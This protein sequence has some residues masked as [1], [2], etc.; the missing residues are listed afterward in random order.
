MLLYLLIYLFINVTFMGFLYF[1]GSDKNIES[2]TEYEM[3]ILEEEEK[4]NLAP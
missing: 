3:Y 1:T 2:R 4:K